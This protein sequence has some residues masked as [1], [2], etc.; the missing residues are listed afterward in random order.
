M[1]SRN[2]SMAAL[3]VAAALPLAAP[4][5]LSAE[6]APALEARAAGWVASSAY[7]RPAA[8][9]PLAAAGL[10]GGLALD[11]TAFGAAGFRLALEGYAN[12]AGL[13]DGASWE[14]GSPYPLSVAATGN[15][16]L[17]GALDLKE[18]W[19][20]FALGD[21]DARIGKQ[22]LAW[23]LADGS[24][25]T[26]NLDARHV[27]TRLVSTLD[28]QKMGTIAAN[29]V[30]NLPGNLG[31]IQG[32]FM[33]LSIPNDMPSIAMDR[34]VSSPPTSQRIVIEED[35]AP[36]WSFDNV[37]GGLRALLY[38]GN[39]S[40]S[41][42]WL[43]CLDR[44]PDFSVAYSGSF[45]AFT[46]RITPFHSRVQQ[47]G[48]DAAWLVGGFDLRSEWALTMTADSSG[49]DPALRNSALSGVLQASR[50]FLD[51]KLSASL[52]WSPRLVVG[53]KDAA[54]YPAAGDRYLAS[55]LAAYNG[56]AYAFEQVGSAR[57]S[58]KLLGETLQPEALFLAE[59]AARDYLATASVSYNVADGVNLKAG[60]GVYGSFREAGDP[61]REWGTFSNSRIIDNDYLFVELRLSY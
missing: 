52:A 32:V 2:A 53:H 57:L 56:Q 30:Y 31:S 14:A 29:V 42:S 44:Y 4:A 50:S 39:L 34:T 58:A 48:L 55:M 19:I 16:R 27:G 11:G 45:P 13:A 18:A 9:D 17:V 49:E 41:G 40:L 21:L 7:C 28:E 54:D 60:G 37:E 61:E 26:D 25:P 5:A 33:P 59:L 12:L 15:G 23:G 24:N 20:D 38:L 43:S 36:S 3:A 47:F 46:T 8:A 35:E 10:R 22:V 1:M 6:G 51:G